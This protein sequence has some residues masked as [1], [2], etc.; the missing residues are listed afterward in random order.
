MSTPRSTIEKLVQRLS[1]SQPQQWC[2]IA[3][4][5]KCYL[6]PDPLVLGAQASAS[7]FAL[8]ASTPMDISKPAGEGT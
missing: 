7:R 6:G 1:E 8:S 2:L 3:P 5:G 4:D